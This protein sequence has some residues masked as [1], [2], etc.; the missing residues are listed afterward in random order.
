[1][2][3]SFHFAF[4][5]RPGSSQSPSRPSFC[6]LCKTSLTVWREIWK[7]AAIFS[8]YQPCAFNLIT[9]V[10]AVVAR[11]FHPGDNCSESLTFCGTSAVLR[12]NRVWSCV[13]V[14]EIL[15]NE[16]PYTSYLGRCI[17][18]IYLS[19]HS[20]VFSCL[21]T[22]TGV[23]V[24]ILWLIPSQCWIKPFIANIWLNHLCLSLS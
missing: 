18:R 15:L 17:L 7:W 16:R 13:R 1:M 8:T 3:S 23:I 20:F 9:S 10:A 19:L 14:S 24:C 4:P 5:P 2:S 11:M 12:F 22:Y 6:H 21:L